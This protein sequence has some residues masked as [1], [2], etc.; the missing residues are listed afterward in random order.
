MSSM[1]SS[2]GDSVRRNGAAA[3]MELARSGLGLSKRVQGNVWPNQPCEFSILFT[4]V[5]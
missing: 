4:C 2:G 1:S 5:W 3:A